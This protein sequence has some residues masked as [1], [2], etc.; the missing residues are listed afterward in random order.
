MEKTITLTIAFLFSISLFSQDQ[1][2]PAWATWYYECWSVFTPPHIETITVTGD[3]VIQGINCKIMKRFSESY[4]YE[5]N[6]KV[7]IY[8]PGDATFGQLYDFNAQAGDQWKVKLNEALLWPFDSMTV[9]VDSVVNREVSGHSLKTQ[10][11]SFYDDQGGLM[12]NDSIYENI[13]SAHWLLSLFESIDPDSG[14]ADEGGP[15]NLHCFDN[16]YFFPLEFNGIACMPFNDKERREENNLFSVSPNPAIDFLQ[17]LFNKGRNS[18]NGT[19]HIFDINGK[20]VENRPFENTSIIVIPLDGMP[21]G[22]Y[23]LK[24]LENGAVMAVERFV[25]SK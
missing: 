2:A 14:Y 8:N 13:G 1:W 6:G 11:V 4:T 9:E 17:V 19:F 10:M 25:I 24:Y 15:C 5:E 21:A 16:P 22:L 20:L 3:T 12:G 7:F 18:Y 23:F